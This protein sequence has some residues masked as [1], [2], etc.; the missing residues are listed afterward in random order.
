MQASLAAPDRSTAA[1]CRDHALLFAMY[2]AGARVQ[3]TP[4][5]RPCDLEL[6]GPRQALLRGKGGKRRLCPLR[7]ETAAVLRELL[8]AGGVDPTDRQPLFRNRAGH[9]LTRFGVR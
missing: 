7:Q 1:G 2:N 5:L 9:P 6:D 3:Q 4:D 8:R